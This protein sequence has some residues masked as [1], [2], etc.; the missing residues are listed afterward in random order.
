MPRKIPHF[1]LPK[2]RNPFARMKPVRAF[3]VADEIPEVAKITGKAGKEGSAI[4]KLAKKAAVPLA[5]GGIPLAYMALTSV[6]EETPEDQD[7][8]GGEGG[9]GEDTSYLR[10]LINWLN[11]LFGWAGAGGGYYPEG[12]PEGYPYG[13]NDYIYPPEYGGGEYPIGYENLPPEYGYPEGYV[14][15]GYVPESW[16]DYVAPAEDFA[17]DVL[18][19]IEGVPVIGDLAAEARRSGWALPFLVVGVVGAYGAYKYGYPK[20]KKLLHKKGGRKKK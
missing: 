5:V 13:Y 16:Q 15:A 17:Q 7:R 4:A 19:A 10:D 3:K 20:L 12:Y 6:P 18:G 9:G 2:L 1:E 11:G 14:P 8:G